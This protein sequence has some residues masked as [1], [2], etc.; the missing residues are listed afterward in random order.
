MASNYIGNYC[1]D[2]FTIVISKDDFVHTVSGFADGTF[3]SMNRLVPSSTPYQGVGR[4]NSFG[5]VKRAVTGM[6]VD[7]TLHQYSPSNTVLQQLQIADAEVT[8]N[9]WVFSVTIKDLSGQTVASSNSA[10]IAAPPAVEFSSDTSTRDWQIYLFGSD[11]FIGGN[12][13][14]APAEV[15][16]VEA[17]GGTVEDKW[18]LNP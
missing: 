8:D 18:R 5:R 1:P 10:I 6:T 16:A 17:A 13:P 11:L 3:V 12:I 9:S 7:V 15:A 2:D 4:S 14:L